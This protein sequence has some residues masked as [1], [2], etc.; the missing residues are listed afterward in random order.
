MTKGGRGASGPVHPGDSHPNG[1][2]SGLRNRSA[3]TSA[4]GFDEEMNLLQEARKLLDLIDDH[5]GIEKSPCLQFLSHSGG[6]RAQV[7]QD[8]RVQEVVD[9]GLGRKGFSDQHGFAGLVMGTRWP[10]GRERPVV[11]QRPTM[12]EPWRRESVI[13]QLKPCP[14]AVFGVNCC[15]VPWG[16]HVHFDPPSR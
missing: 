11:G 1:A 8:A 2:G 14:G 5:Q 10:K 13:R 3:E 4:S 9:G 15:F 16:A 12:T 7:E 6:I